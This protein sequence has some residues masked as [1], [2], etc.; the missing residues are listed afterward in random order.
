VQSGT[1]KAAASPL[2][3]RPD[4]GSEVR[5]GTLPRFSEFVD[6][7]KRRRVIQALLGRGIFSSDVLQIYEPV[8]HGLHLPG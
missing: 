5:R 1:A 4:T 7:P 2:A 8:M 3:L 6:G